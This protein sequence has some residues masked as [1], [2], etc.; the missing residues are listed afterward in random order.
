MVWLSELEPI[1]GGR[2]LQMPDDR[3]ITNLVTD[4][5]K[6]VVRPGSVFFAIHGDRHDGHNFIRELY[7]SGLRNFVVEKTI[8]IAGMPDVAILETNS[9][10]DALQAVA[11]HHRKKFSIPVF[12]ITGSNGKTIVKEWLYQV[13][14]SER[15]ILKTPGSYNSQIG[16]PLSVWQLN[17]SHDLAIFEAGISMPGEME[18]LKRI[19][20]P[21]IGIFTTIGT[22]HSEG[23]DSESRKIEEKLKLFGA[24]ECLIYCKDHTDIDREV[25]RQGIP[26]LHW[27]VHPDSNVHLSVQ[28]NAAVV[29]YN[30]KHVT[31]KLPFSDRAS[32]ENFMHVL[33]ALLYLGYEFD[34]IE[35]AMMQLRAVPMRLEM[36]EG[37]NQ[38]QIID[39]TYNNDLGGLQISLDFL[40]NQHHRRKKI[41]ILSDILQSGEEETALVKQIN[42]LL[43]RNSITFFI[44]I[45]PV[46]KRNRNLI[47]IDAQ[48]FDSTEEFL[49]DFDRDSMQHAM[50]LIKGARIFGFEQIV[51]ALQLKSHATVM[52][53]DLGAMVHN[54]NF[55]RS[56]INSDTKIMAMVKAFAYGSG[57]QEVASLLQYH[58]VDYLGVAFADE[59][60][61][62]RKSNIRLPIMVMSP[63]PDAFEALVEYN[64]EPEVYSFSILDQLIGFLGGRACKVHIKID[65]GMHRLGFEV[66]DM[67]QLA[68]RLRNNKNI[69]VASVFSHL[70]GA[71]DKIHDAFSK[72]QA[73]RFVKCAEILS[74]LSGERPIW[75]LANSMGILRHADYQFDMVRLGIGLYGAGVDPYVNFLRPV[76]TLKTFVT[77]LRKIEKGE[78]IGYG[79]RGKA[80]KPMIV[81]TIGIG[82]ADG[83]SRAFSNGVGEVLIN[84]VRCPVVG[85]VCMDMTMIDVSNAPVKEGDEVIV[86]GKELPIDEVASK[87]N[88]ISYEILA[89]TSER[90]KRVFWAESI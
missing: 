3:K 40:N 74:A 47:G 17:D 57:M 53:I 60:A 80:A 62:L 69:V 26:S 66:D 36:K 81:A 55:F 42:Q 63:S 23:F 73:S 34:W 49:R 33:T 27:G 51:K 32:I 87:I 38:C 18:R 25:M 1:T 65:T 75:H 85:N 5:R 50:I 30:G 13:L 28:G 16:V 46:L 86:Y 24:V 31:I 54:L 90:V 79:R 48:F 6:A 37:I 45:G 59:G 39:D 52:E 56:R 67:P 15:H 20:E 19:I 76:A 82:Y 29:A 8:D 64:L 78:T 44:G 43:T 12:G 68:E 4:S 7:D 9:S 84:G 58:K 22:A 77:Q 41:L 71:D 21:T 35:K 61:T 88:T 89:N 10:V 72:D 11:A 14:M 2:F 70:A 83:F